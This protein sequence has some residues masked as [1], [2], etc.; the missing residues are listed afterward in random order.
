MMGL[1]GLALIFDMD[2]VL[3][4]STSTHVEAWLLYLKR[5]GIETRAIED[6]ML[7]K[8]NDD[9][10]RD[11]FRGITLSDEEVLEH[12]ARKEQLYRDIMG[13]K[14]DLHMV[15]GV[16]Q[17]LERHRN[18]PIG[19][20][21]NGEPANVDL[22]LRGT[23]TKKYFRSVVSGHEVRLPKPHPD[24]YLKVA[25]LLGVSPGKCVVFEDS[26]TGIEAARAAGMR[27]AGLTTTLPALPGVDLAVPDF[28]DAGL[29][30]WLQSI[31]SSYTAV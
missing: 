27:V 20:A 8:R 28:L 12:G 19:L 3:I 18:L 23:N 9:I 10:V 24:I 25:D 29:E 15:P 1:S 31:A 5:L 26:L 4:D 13:P 17:F 14:L 30:P 6:R 2:G 11:F 21:T 16:I 7:G 22:V